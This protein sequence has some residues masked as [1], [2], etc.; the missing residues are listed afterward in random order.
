VHIC[1]GISCAC[2]PR[3]PLKLPTHLLTTAFLECVYFLMPATVPELGRWQTTSE[4]LACV[5]FVIMFGM[6]GPKG[7]LHAWPQQQTD[8][9]MME[10]DDNPNQ[11]ARENTRRL[12]GVG[13]FFGD[14]DKMVLCSLLSATLMPTDWLL[15]RLDKLDSLSVS[16]SSRQQGSVTEPPLIYLLLTPGRSPVEWALKAFLGLCG[17]AGQ[18]GFVLTLWWK[19]LG[20]TQQ[21][22]HKWALRGLVTVAHQA[23][24]IYHRLALQ[25]EHY[26]LKLWRTPAAIFFSGGKFTQAAQAAAQD[27]F[28][29]PCGQCVDKSLTRKVLDRCGDPTSFLRSAELECLGAN[30]HDLALLNLD[31]ER[32][33]ARNRADTRFSHTRS[34]SRMCVGAAVAVWAI[35]HERLGGSLPSHANSADLLAAG[36]DIHRRTR[37]WSGLR[38]GIQAFT[39][40]WQDVCKQWRNTSETQPMVRARNRKQGRGLVRLV[41]AK[42]GWG[43]WERFKKRRLDAWGS[44]PALAVTWRQKAVEE[45]ARRALLRAASAQAEA[46]ADMPV[47]TLWQCGDDCS[48]IRIGLV[49]E[50]V[51]K[52]L[53]H[54]PPASH[55]W[56]K[57]VAGPTGIARQIAKRQDKVCMAT[58]PRPPG[59]LHP[60]HLDKTCC[61]TH[62]GL[63]KTADAEVFDLVLHI[64]AN[65]N[66]IFTGSM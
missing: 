8:R 63:C 57:R 5:V 58:D 25:T 46:E 13:A 26:P 32:M 22:W 39:L 9:L 59:K 42:R 31:L 38:D 61:Q 19:R 65:L 4:A 7:W 12:S 43:E 35:E 28:R 1:D 20:S 10:N 40:Y 48:P 21:W 16:K 45:S 23:A 15:R 3:D 24:N 62:I 41:R 30:A 49:E 44:D 50:T 54:L 6:L 47:D 11:F 36:V 27:L 14:A 29:T 51:Q 34:A 60:L 55:P 66:T 56:A 52:N 18:V 33:Q 17:P 2:D 64:Q 37:H 53:G